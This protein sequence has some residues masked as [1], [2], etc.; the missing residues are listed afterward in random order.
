MTRLVLFGIRRAW[1]ERM[2][3][4][5]SGDTVGLLWVLWLLC[6]LFPFPGT[7]W[8]L[9]PRHELCHQ[10]G[11]P[12]HPRDHGRRCIMQASGYFGA[13]HATASFLETVNFVMGRGFQP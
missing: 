1:R 11:E 7:P 9:R 10:R 8:M 5:S 6:F 13:R 4:Y 3:G 12:H 2:L